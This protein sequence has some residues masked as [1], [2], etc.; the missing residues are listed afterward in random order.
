MWHPRRGRWGGS[1]AVPSA[2]GVTTPDGRSGEHIRVAGTVQG[3][4]FRPFVA[5]LAADLGLSGS[6]RNDGA[7]VRIALAGPQA[8]RDAFVTALRERPPPLARIEGV[9]RAPGPVAAA[10]FTIEASA[11]GAAC[12]EVPPDAA[13]CADCARE[14]LDPA[15]RRFGYPFASC[16]A[17][18]PRY[19]VLAALPF[20]RARTAMAAFPLCGACAA[21]YADPADRRCHAQ[22]L[23]CAAC[24]PRLTALEMD[25]ARA[26]LRAGGVLAVKGLG[27]FQLCADATNEPAVARLRAWKRRPRRP[28]ALMAHDIGIITRHAAVGPA[29]RGAL[30]SVERP[31]VLLPA[32]G[33]PLA[34][35][36]APGQRRLGFM[37]P[38]TP[39]HLLLTEGLDRPIVAT[40]ANRSGAPIALTPDGLEADG[41]LDHDR[42]I[43][44]R[45][46]DAVVQ[47]VG[48]AVQVLRRARG[49]APG[50]LP[51]PPGLPRRAVLALGGH[52]KATVAWSRCGQVVLS[53]HIGDLDH[54]DTVAA[55]TETVEGL[56]ALLGQDP[57]AAAVDLHPAYRSSAW[58]RRWAADHGRP[59]VEVQH[60]HAHIA[61]C[62]AEAG[63]PAGQRVLGLALDGL[64]YGADGTLWGGE[65]LL[66]TY[67]RAERVGG[68]PAV[69]LLGGDRAALEPWRNLYAHLRA[70]FSWDELGRW[71][72]AEGLQARP[73]AL[74][75]PMM[76]GG[77]HA[78]PASSAGRLFDAVAAAVG[79]FP[80][81]VSYEGEAAIALEGL[82]EEG[83]LRAAP[84]W[85]VSLEVRDGRLVFGWRGLWAA[86]LDALEDG[87][88]PAEVAAAFH[89]TLADALVRAATRLC[90]ANDLR[91]V[92]L[93]GGC[94]QNRTLHTLVAD[95]LQERGLIVHHHRA[96]PPNDGGLALGQAVVAAARLGAP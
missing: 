16:T 67:G 33:E 14:V 63:V 78:P 93:S 21:E 7:G 17:C 36:V 64:G 69:P 28:F 44:R 42:P 9:S 79:L 74:L 12:T 53:P 30:Q 66:C 71:A 62:M 51:L 57:E 54:P 13:V 40:S 6:V 91:A 45:A 27:G 49:Y 35:S 87:A 61:A 88:T 55:W 85:P 22:T 25:E 90:R 73:V 86:L 92:A 18:G 4:G 68:L 41:V 65:L 52:L 84:V 75:D 81:R 20:D 29:A 19:T 1:W 72:V 8:A 15:D 48:G 2:D 3:V 47:L 58:G 56:G 34:P 11:P 95:A 89:R 60:H 5:R 43:L 46:D 39:L 10:G 96:V 82:A 23:A 94:W 24:G 38:T 37:L 83:D 70:A 77:P 80:E 50:P 31:I 59:V 32:V 26:L 76:A